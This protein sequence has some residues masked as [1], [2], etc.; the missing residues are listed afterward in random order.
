V[1]S[2]LEV[3]GDGKNAA[4]QHYDQ[5]GRIRLSRTLENAATEDPYNEATGI[6]VQT[7][8]AYQAPTDP[9]NSNG[10]YTLT[11]NPYR[12]VTSGGASGETTMG[13]TRSYSN[14][15]GWH[16][17]ATTYSGAN[18]PAPW[19]VIRTPLAPSRQIGTWTAPWLPIRP[20]NSASVRS[21]FSGSF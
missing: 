11:S 14:K 4:I 19:V 1:L 21:M 7:R 12:A 2:D 13:W 10:A 8:Y 18:L 3:K 6:K 15:T 16:S 9:A 17:E 5:L 20:E